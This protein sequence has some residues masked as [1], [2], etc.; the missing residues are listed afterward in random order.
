MRVVDKIYEPDELVE[1]LDNLYKDNAII[2]FI[3]AEVVSEGETFC[4]MIDKNPLLELGEIKK[5]AYSNSR[6]RLLD[7]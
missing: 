3:T 1:S 4:A 6:Q 2:N 7:S 5:L